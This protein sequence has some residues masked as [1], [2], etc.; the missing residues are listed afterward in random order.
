[1]SSSNLDIEKTLNAKA[2]LQEMIGDVDC[3]KL[4]VNNGYFEILIQ[5]SCEGMSNS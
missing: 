2:V 4:L 5:V 3:F 1:M